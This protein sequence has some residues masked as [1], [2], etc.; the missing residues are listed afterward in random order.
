MRP[1]DRK[2][3][4]GTRVLRDLLLSRTR[5]GETMGQKGYPWYQGTEGIS[6]YRGRDQ[7]RPWD[8]KVIHGAR[9]LRGSPTIE[10]ETR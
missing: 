10:D 1:W 5:P 2:V 7:V 6:Y 3:I 8:R 4:R 9:M